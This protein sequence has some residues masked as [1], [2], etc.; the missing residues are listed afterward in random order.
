MTLARRLIGYESIV[1]FELGLAATCN[2]YRQ[3]FAAP[4]IAQCSTSLK[5]AATA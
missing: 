3:Q 4:D 2:W 1:P 5:F